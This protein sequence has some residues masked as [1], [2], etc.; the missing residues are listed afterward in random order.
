VNRT[1]KQR[2]KAL[3][4]TISRLGRIVRRI[5]E[6]ESNP[7][8]AAIRWTSLKLIQDARAKLAVT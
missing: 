5:P 4:L 7:N 3:K 6:N 2:R 8:L 1:R